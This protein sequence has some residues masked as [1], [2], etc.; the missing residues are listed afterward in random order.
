MRGT[1][2]SDDGPPERGVRAQALAATLAVHAGLLALLLVQVAEPVRPVAS[3]L[4]MFDVTGLNADEV[5]KPPKAPQPKPKPVPPTPPQPVVVPPTVLPT[6]S[7]MV[8]ALLDQADTATMGGA[9]DLTGP[10]QAALQSSELVAASVPQIPRDQRSVA[11]AIMIWNAAWISPDARFDPAAF[12][13]I[14]N[15]VAETVAAA[16]EEC[17]LQPQGGPRLIMLPGATENTVLALGSGTWRWQDLLDTAQPSDA[18]T[19]TAAI[20]TLPSIFATLQ[21]A[22]ARHDQTN[23]SPR[24]AIAAAVRQ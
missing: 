13:A 18:E 5:S 6:P 14:R 8:V 10:V 22:F 24:Q 19:Q 1:R 17:R 16:S 2:A 3:A 21:R 11:N 9:C 12:D 4:T 23:G 7:A 15:V 20:G